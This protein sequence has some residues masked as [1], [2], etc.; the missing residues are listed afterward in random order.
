ME[1]P[2][3]VLIL[4]VAIGLGLGGFFYGANQKSVLAKQHKQD[5]AAQKQAQKQALQ[6][7]IFEQHKIDLAAQEKAVIEEMAKQH[8]AAIQEREE[9]F[10]TEIEKL[11]TELS[12]GPIGPGALLPEG[13]STATDAA[14]RL[15]EQVAFL[16]EQLDLLRDENARLL[17]LVDRLETKLKSAGSSGEGRSFSAEEQ[18]ALAN[19]QQLTA[20]SRELEYKEPV[21]IIFTD[22]DGMSKAVADSIRPKRSPEQAA[23]LSRAYAA[24]G[25]VTPATDVT[26]EI[27]NLL[28]S[29][30]GAALYTGDNQIIFN[31]DGNL[32]SVHDR[33]SL[34]VAF[35]RALQDQNF[36]LGKVPTPV[37]NNDDRYTAA[38]AL[39]LGDASIIKLRHMMYD[40]AAPGDLRNS[41]TALSPEEF[42]AA[43]PFVR[44]YF[45]F[46]YTMGS[47]FCEAL[48]ERG[49]WQSVNAAIHNP[50]TSTAEI[51][52]PE[53]YLAN[54]PFRAEPYDWPA[55]KLKVNDTAPLWNNVAGE[56][57]ISV[58]LNRAYYKFNMSKQGFYDTDLPPITKSQ[59]KNNP[60]SIAAKG[61]RGDRYLVYANGD[62]AGGTDH[63]YWRSKWASP[64]DAAEFFHGARVA[65]AHAYS[66]DLP[67]IAWLLEPDPAER[68]PI[69][70]ESTGTSFEHTSPR[71]RHLSIQLNPET[72]EVTIINAADKPWLDALKKLN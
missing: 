53:L 14:G 45:L 32:R 24:M 19:T 43:T 6:S 61:W 25:F 16:E 13:A 55:E 20:K 26:A 62:G 29:Q 54:E 57:A 48:H 34:A 30:L 46:P 11:R 2:Q 72:S 4:L 42:A 38:N 22:L 3:T 67:Q 36:D 9:E 63:T 59:F 37:E 68:E 66:I 49:K 64:A 60:G 15:E 7:E 52:H 41:P 18:K 40:I 31:Q 12:A 1:R 17:Q 44:E 10:R 71:K 27:T 21:K 39:L 28:T 51:L 58:Y 47:S 33:T 70:P 69:T 8:D 35:D 50:P 56:L 23:N 5:L 65:F